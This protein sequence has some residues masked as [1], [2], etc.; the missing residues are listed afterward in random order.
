M[1]VG[2]VSGIEPDDNWQLIATNTTTSG[3]STTFNSFS[4]YK[5]LM[6]TF[7]GVYTSAETRH[8]MRFNGDS[9]SN[10]QSLM[11]GYSATPAGYATDKLH[12][13]GW[14]TAGPENGY[15]IIK[16]VNS[17]TLPKIITEGLS[18]V[19]NKNGGI[20]LNES[21]AIT[22]IVITNNDSTAYTAGTFKLYGIPA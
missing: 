7:K 15:V 2:T 21:S 6:I 17:T 16:N 4:G 12:I 14:S 20:W 3:T 5:T 10:Y 1:A 18:Y 19:M 8:I 11:S 13:T 22:S 9:G